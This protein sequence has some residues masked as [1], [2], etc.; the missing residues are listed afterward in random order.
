MILMQLLKNDRIMYAND[1]TLI[2]ILETFGNTNRPTEIEM[3]ITLVTKYLKLQLG[4]I[5]IN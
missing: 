4:F 5:V 3:K 1:I 2:S